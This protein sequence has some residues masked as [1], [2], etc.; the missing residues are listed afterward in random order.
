MNIGGVPLKSLKRTECF[1]YCL[2]CTRC[3]KYYDPFT[4]VGDKL[5]PALVADIITSI[6]H[7]LAN[8]VVLLED[9]EISKKKKKSLVYLKEHK[10]FF[11]LL[12]NTTKSS[13]NL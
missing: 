6:T 2:I 9:D 3:W 10:H 7:M 13:L 1:D 11:I 12:P 8:T 4:S 5:I